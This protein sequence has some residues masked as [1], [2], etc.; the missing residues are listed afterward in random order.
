MEVV[1]FE[2]LYTSI[3]QLRHVSGLVFLFGGVFKK[4][5]TLE[6]DTVSNYRQLFLYV[7]RLRRTFYSIAFRHSNY[8][9][10]YNN[11]FLSL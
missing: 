8:F 5:S 1:L 2:L 4:F 9:P 6:L 3:I 7:E 10:V 11:T